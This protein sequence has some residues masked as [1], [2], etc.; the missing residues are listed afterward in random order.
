MK[1]VNVVEVY[2]SKFSHSMFLLKI[3]CLLKKCILSESQKSLSQQ[4]LVE[5]SLF[6]F[7]FL[8]ALH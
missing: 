4:L 5:V 7:H 3:L 2:T 6:R 1:Y 8:C